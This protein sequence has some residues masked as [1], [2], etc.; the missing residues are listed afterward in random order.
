MKSA[1]QLEV[2]P[3]NE[4]A[5]PSSVSPTDQPIA[6]LPVE[7][8]LIQRSPREIALEEYI[9]LCKAITNGRKLEETAPRAKSRKSPKS[10]SKAATKPSE[11][12]SSEH[13]EP[14]GRRS[15][16]KK[17]LEPEEV[18][19]AAPP[20]LSPVKE[21]PSASK[22][23][24]KRTSTT[25][26]V[27]IVDQTPEK[28][29]EVKTQTA[30]LE[31]PA[32]WQH[33]FEHNF[34][35]ARTSIEPKLQ[36]FSAKLSKRAKNDIF[37][38]LDESAI[39][40]WQSPF[41]WD[42]AVEDC[43]LKYI[44][45]A[46]IAKQVLDPTTLQKPHNFESHR[47]TFKPLQR[48]S[49]NMALSKCDSLLALATGGGKTMCYV[50]PA[51]LEKGLTIVISPL[52]SLIQDQ[53]TLLDS[54]GVSSAGLSCQMS[55]EQLESVYDQILMET[56]PYKLVYVTPERIGR[57]GRFLKVLLELRRRG[58]LQR[59]VIDEAHCIS[60]WGH[61]FRKDYRRLSLLKEHLPDVPIMAVTGTCTPTVRQDIAE[62]L[63]LA[64]A[65]K[66]KWPEAYPHAPVLPKPI[67][68]DAS[69]DSQN[70]NHATMNRYFVLQSGFNRENLWFQ[71]APKSPETP[72]ADML[73]YILNHGLSRECGIVFAMTTNDAERL[74]EFFAEQGLQTAFYHGGMSPQERQAA[75]AKWARGEAKLMCTTVA[76]GMGIDKS[77][78]RYV[79]HSTMPTSLEAYYQQAGRAGRDGAPADCVLF[80]QRKDRIKLEHVIKLHAHLSQQKQRISEIVKLREAAEKKL[81]EEIKTTKRKKSKSK[82]TIEDENAKKKL[83]DEEI[84]AEGAEKD[85]NVSVRI[86]NAEF[87]EEGFDSSLNIVDIVD[88]P[89]EESGMVRLLR[90]DGSELLF[91]GFHPDYNASDVSEMVQ[92]EDDPM[93]AFV[94]QMKTEKL[95]DVT[96]F[97]RERRTCRR[98]HLMRFFGQS[99][100]KRQCDHT[101][102][103]CNPSAVRVTE[104][105]TRRGQAEWDSLKTEREKRRA[106]NASKPL[107]PAVAKLHA[108]IQAQEEDTMRELNEIAKKAD[109]EDYERQDTSKKGARPAIP[110]RVGDS[111]P[112]ARKQRKTRFSVLGD[113]SD[114]QL[115]QDQLEYG[116]KKTTSAKKA[117]KADNAASSPAQD[118]L[119][120]LSKQLENKSSTNTH[121]ALED[122]P[123]EK[124]PIRPKIVASKSID[125]K[126]TPSDSN[127]SVSGLDS[128]LASIVQVSEAKAARRSAS[129]KKRTSGS[130][131]STKKHVI[132]Q[133][134]ED[135]YI[136]TTTAFPRDYGFGSGVDED[137]EIVVRPKRTPITSHSDIPSVPQQIHTPNPPMDVVSTILSPLPSSIDTKTEKVRMT[138]KDA[139]LLTE[140]RKACQEIANDR[141]TS[142]KNVMSQQVMKAVAEARPQTILQLAAVKGIGPRRAQ[143]FANFILPLFKDTTKE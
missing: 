109:E 28:S 46:S 26:D 40:F 95:D 4:E 15:R 12:A 94:R 36:V 43:A 132:M 24:R 142:V 52:I 123:K 22:R 119:K 98:V 97:C 79:L 57:N 16:S 141:E 78:V 39:K 133:E 73:Y 75:H 74:A 99:F 17:A 48:E 108:A 45:S 93:D 21:T 1:S 89:E 14:K 140:V 30:P 127:D 47:V 56:P 103:I 83:V 102:D 60:E 88:I 42:K 116:S 138:A 27:E 25:E 81:L 8:T 76:F 107:S 68:E 34:D 118:L 59:V 66:Q 84:L 65:N 121:R 11:E 114:Y 77:N 115:I 33:D 3:T 122:E 9:E 62:Q 53:V 44:L 72:M 85:E 134:D 139:Q 51:L 31:L 37:A 117:P 135:G 64:F 92:I 128:L 58:L 137:E 41:E 20:D 7:E 111:S 63:G 120:Q 32:K 49:I 61:D 71:V 13:K 69:K 80:F 101:C 131:F 96:S 50:L 5:I 124:I 19:P 67:A 91:G 23:T 136:R 125:P 86:P 110:T 70:A 106:K 87:D 100:V 105:L 29:K 18:S 112:L 129:S 35:S 55:H 82:A 10:R 130:S 6:D 38:P 54:M 143:N 113:P 2:Q 104:K 90:A 126:D